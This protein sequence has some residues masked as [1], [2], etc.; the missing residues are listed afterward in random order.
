MYINL[1]CPTKNELDQFT[2][3][4]ASEISYSNSGD[5]Y[6]PKF[7]RNPI[8]RH[9]MP[10]FKDGSLFVLFIST[11]NKITLTLILTERN[12]LQFQR[13]R[14]RLWVHVGHIAETP[15]PIEIGMHHQ[16]DFVQH[17]HR[18]EELR[19]LHDGGVGRQ[20]FNEDL[21]IFLWHE[22][23]SFGCRLKRVLVI[24]FFDVVLHF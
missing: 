24:M 8:I 10:P 19:H 13:L 6:T 5:S 21:A 9:G 3:K 1:K 16:S 4:K 14:C 11:N 23:L 20:L 22:T 12:L 7:Q 17:V 15:V 18:L 2:L